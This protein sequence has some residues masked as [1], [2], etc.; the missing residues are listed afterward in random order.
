ML[1]RYNRFVS[2]LNTDLISQFIS[3]PRFHFTFSEKK[4]LAQY[5][6][7]ICLKTGVP[8]GDFLKNPALLKMIESDCD[9]VQKGKIIFRYV[10]EN[11]YPRSNGKDRNASRV[12]VNGESTGVQNLDTRKQLIN[13]YFYGEGVFDL[14][15][16]VV[17]LIRSCPLDCAYCFLREVYDD[18]KFKVAPDYHQLEREIHRIRERETGPLYLNAG[19]NADSLIEDAEYHLVENLWKIVQ[20]IP[21]TFIEFRTKTDKIQNLMRLN[22]EKRIVMAFSLNSEEDRKK[23]ESTTA[24]IEERIHAAAQLQSK[25]WMIGLR[26]EPILY[27]QHYAEKYRELFGQIFRKISP[28]LVHSVAFGC[29][30]LTKGLSKMIGATHPDVMAEEWILGPDK[31]FRYCREIRVEIY[32]NLIASLRPHF[33]NEERIILSTEPEEIWRESGYTLKTMPQICKNFEPLKSRRGS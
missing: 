24:S 31:K 21:N 27:T 20:P 12:P 14:K 17:S 3:D 33:P 6:P 25:G 26:F 7:Q 1:Q 29:L 23:F 10:R 2:Q 30:R 18:P 11:R 16:Y 32:K 8:A 13:P 28:S 15:E 5:I 9:R 4:L 19:E 22:S